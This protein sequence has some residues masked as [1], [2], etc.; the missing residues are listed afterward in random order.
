MAVIPRVLFKNVA[1][2][3]GRFLSLSAIAKGRMDRREHQAGSRPVEEGVE[4]EKYFETV[5]LELWAYFLSVAHVLVD[6]TEFKSVDGIFPTMETMKQVFNGIPFEEMHI[7]H[8]KCSKNNVKITVT[9]N[10][11]AVILYTSCGVEGFKNCRKKTEV[12]G[13]ATGIAAGMKALRRGVKNVRIIISGLGPGRMSSIRG[14][15]L[16]GVQV[17]SITDW[18]PLPELGPRPRKQRRI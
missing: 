1:P 15:A 14:L 4:G 6:F 8:V 5:G 10:H 16:A 18:T 9:D 12:A 13:Q 2:A 7:C 3:V 11:G 17:I